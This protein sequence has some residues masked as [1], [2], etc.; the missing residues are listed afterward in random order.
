MSFRILDKW[1]NFKFNKIIPQLRNQNRR[2]DFT[3]K[4]F[5]EG[6]TY[7]RSQLWWIVRP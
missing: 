5:S 7:L 3:D 1:T 2:E 6:I 4:C